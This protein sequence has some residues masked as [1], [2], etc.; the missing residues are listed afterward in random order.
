MGKEQESVEGTSL[1]NLLEES[2]VE[3]RDVLSPPKEGIPSFMV[4]QPCLLVPI[5]GR[6]LLPLLV[7]FG[8]VELLKSLVEAV[9]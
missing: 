2:R 3:G 4:P 5:G 7:A 8:R 9:S 1:R 6:T